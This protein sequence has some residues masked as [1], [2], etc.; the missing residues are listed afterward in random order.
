MASPES[1]C[2]SGTSPE[3]DCPPVRKK[4]RTSYRPDQLKVL[5]R[6]F[7]ENPYPDA[8]RIETLSKDLEIAETKLR[9]RIFIL[10]RMRLLEARHRYLPF[11]R[12]R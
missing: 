6:Q 7:K 12:R 10:S 1:G 9:V 2:G 5:E 11:R 8:D 4:A 3:A